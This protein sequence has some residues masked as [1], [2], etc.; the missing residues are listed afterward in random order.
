MGLDNSRQSIALNVLFCRIHYAILHQYYLKYL[1]IS[2]FL[3][4]L[5]Q[6]EL[7]H[8]SVLAAGNIRQDVWWLSNKPAYTQCKVVLVQSALPNMCK[9]T[10]CNLPHVAALPIKP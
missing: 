9:L 1:N 4:A 6:W 3:L 2:N 8:T 10:W 7:I 5:E